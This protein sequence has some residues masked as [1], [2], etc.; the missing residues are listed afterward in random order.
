MKRLLILPVLIISLI[1]VPVQLFA[2]RSISEYTKAIEQSPA[3]RK[4]KFYL[5]RGVAYKENGDISEA[6]K[7][8]STS[9]QLKPSKGAFL[10][11]GEMYFQRGALNMAINDFTEAIKINPTQDVYRLRGLT[12]LV[13]GNLELAIEDGTMIINLSPNDS[14]SYN[15]RM[16]AYAQ[17]GESK[18]ARE[19]ARRALALD[20]KNKIA[21]EV[22]LNNPEKIILQGSRGKYKSIQVED[23]NIWANSKGF[24]YTRKDQE[25]QAEQQ[26]QNQPEAP[27]QQRR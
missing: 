18:L 24:A 4:Y 10:R 19:D 8:F 26:K 23:Y 21:Q 27:K 7:D 25:N 17:I 3:D 14:E 15:I 20:R 12:Y 5:L 11:R 2:A 6:I 1:A 22:L 9:I 13:Q 16:E